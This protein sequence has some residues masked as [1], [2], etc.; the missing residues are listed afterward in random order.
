MRTH[1]KWLIVLFSLGMFSCG[2]PSFL[3]T[4]GNLP[5]YSSDITSFY[6][7]EDGSTTPVNANNTTA[8]IILGDPLNPTPFTLHWTISY[9]GPVDLTIQVKDLTSASPVNLFPTTNCSSTSTTCS[10]TQDAVCTY[11]N[12]VPQ[13]VGCTINGNSQTPANVSTLDLAKVSG[14]LYITLQ[15]CAGDGNCASYPGSIKVNFPP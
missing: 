5:I 9:P 8:V 12:T 3:G 10:L 1:K 14:D 13:S 4:A 7:L 2:E 15:V 11:D 6:L